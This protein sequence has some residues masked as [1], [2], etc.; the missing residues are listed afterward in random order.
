MFIILWC[1]KNLVLIFE[2]KC[3][4]SSFLNFS[5]SFILNIFGS[6]FFSYLFSFPFLLFLSLSFSSFYRFLLFL[7]FLCIQSFHVMHDC[8]AD[9][10]RWNVT[11]VRRT[12][13]FAQCKIVTNCNHQL[14]ELKQ[15]VLKL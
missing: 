12:I 4:F 9:H 8:C 5:L 2:L 1:A 15:K 13:V 3:H 14:P 11:K 6:S 10:E 7:I